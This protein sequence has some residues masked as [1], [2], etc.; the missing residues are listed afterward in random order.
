MKKRLFS[1]ALAASLGAAM[2]PSAAFAVDEQAPNYWEQHT[3]AEILAGCKVTGVHEDT[4]TTMPIFGDIEGLNEALEN[5]QLTTENDAPLEVNAGD[6]LTYKATIDASAVKW[7]M[8]DL[9]RHFSAQTWLSLPGDGFDNNKWGSALIVPEAVSEFTATITAPPEITFPADLGNYTFDGGPFNLKSITVDPDGHKATVVMAL[10]VNK[11]THNSPAPGKADGMS[12]TITF[13]D[14]YQ[15][16]PATLWLQATGVKLADDAKVDTNYTIE[17]EVHGFF[18]GT[19]CSPALAEDGNTNQKI[20]PNLEWDAVQDGAVGV[21]NVPAD[22]PNGTQPP[23]EPDGTDAIIT[24]GT[25]SAWDES[26]IWFTVHV[27]GYQAIFEFESGTPGKALPESIR[28]MSPERLRD[29]RAKQKLSVN[30]RALQL[31]DVDGTTLLTDPATKFAN[32]F[33]A[34]EVLVDKDGNIVTDKAKAAGKWTFTKWT[35]EGEV[36]FD[37]TTDTTVRF[38]GKWVYEE[39]KAEQPKAEQPKEEQ[40]KP[41]EPKKELADTGASAGDAGVLAALLLAAGGVAV[42]TRRKLS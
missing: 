39:F 33:Y 28:N 40:P 14:I 41:E 9:A 13:N 25:A 6:T 22:Y 1:V 29:L 15:A 5:S 7:Q 23:S 38:D 2:M 21:P 11:I 19:A 34:L 10:D 12:K 35:P 20:T 26:R 16:I 4:A 18:N 32:Q 37:G 24:N 30:G 8:Y 17:G 36:A 3:E 31:F 42:A 27:K